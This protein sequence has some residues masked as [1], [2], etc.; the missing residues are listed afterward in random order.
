[1]YVHKYCRS[2][3][4]VVLAAGAEAKDEQVTVGIGGC[5]VLPI[6]TAFAVKQCSVPLALNL[7]RVRQSGGEILKLHCSYL[8]CM[9]TTHY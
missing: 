6:W 8:H 7:S 9:G 4:L 1:M 2:V 3:Y 5:K